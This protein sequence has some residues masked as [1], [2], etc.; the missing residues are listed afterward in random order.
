VPVIKRLAVYSGLTLVFLLMVAAILTY[1]ASH[2]GWRVDCV[3]TGSM[4]PGLLTGSLVITRPVGPETIEVGDIITFRDNAGN[5]NTITH[6]VIGVWNNSPL[7]FQ[8]KG[9]A[10]SGPDPFTV[11]ARNVIGK[12]C[13]SLPYAGYVIYFLKT[14]AGFAVGIIIPTIILLFV[15]VMN[16]RKQLKKHKQQNILE[17]VK[18]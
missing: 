12:V 15:Y 1:V 8:T 11:P 14:P 13:F 2:V 3:L 7:Y 9:D 4:E 18:R 17:T 5:R 6:R 10:C 16:I